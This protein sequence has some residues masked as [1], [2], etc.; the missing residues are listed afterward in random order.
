MVPTV[1]INGE[2]LSLNEAIWRGDI[3]YESWSQSFNE[4]PEDSIWQHRNGCKYRVLFLTNG[5]DRADYP[6]TVIYQGENGKRWSR[7]LWDWSRSMTF[8]ELV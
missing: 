6:R 8:V 5:H 1:V 3:T 4:P 7:P 2:R